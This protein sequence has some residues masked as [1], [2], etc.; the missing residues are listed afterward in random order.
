MSTAALKGGAGKGGSS[1]LDVFDGSKNSETSDEDGRKH[2]LSRGA[3]LQLV[4]PENS[5]DRLEALKDVTEAS[6]F[7]E[8]IR[9]ALRLYEGLLAETEA[10]GTLVVKRENG[11][12]EVVPLY[13]AL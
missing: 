4:L 10:G 12:E 3:R 11:D 8:V 7:A 6:S 13:R 9:R 1:K 2:K 5:V